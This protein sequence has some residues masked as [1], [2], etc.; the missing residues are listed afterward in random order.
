MCICEGR[1]ILMSNHMKSVTR[2]VL[3]RTAW[4][5]LAVVL[6]G[7]LIGSIVIR[8]EHLQKTFLLR[9]D[10]CLKKIEYTLESII[11]LPSYSEEFASECNHLISLIEEFEINMEAG[12]AYVSKSIPSPDIFH[13]FGQVENAIQGRLDSDY[14][15]GAFTENGFSEK[16]VLFL[17]ELLNATKILRS[18][19][20]IDSIWNY[21]GSLRA[22]V[23][24][25]ETF[26]MTWQLDAERTPSGTSPFDVLKSG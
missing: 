6:I 16:K 21:T 23:R 9:I 24:E 10:N 12:S 5:F 8:Q 4:P 14:T 20:D 3:K 13:G 25:Y 26:S 17:N 19:I 15:V 1:D 18:S 7:S 11:L 22:Y 2:Q